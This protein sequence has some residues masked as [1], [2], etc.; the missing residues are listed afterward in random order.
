MKI[1]LLGE[2]SRLHN[3]LKEGL[4]SLGHKVTLLSDGDGFKNFPNDLSIR[5]SLTNTFPLRYFK[6]GIYKIF[7][8]DLSELERGLRCFFLLKK[9]KNFDVVQLINEKP[10]KTTPTVERYLLKRIFYNNTNVF[11][12]S[13]GVDTIS[14][15][16]MM[17]KK[18]RYSLLDPYFTNPKLKNEFNYVLEYNLNSQN[19]THD[20]VFN[21]IKGVIA[22]DFDY[23]LPL[24]NHKQFLGLIPNPVNLKE[25]SFQQPPFDQKIVIFLGIN[26]GTYHAKGIPYFEKA[27]ASI[28]NTYRD[29]VKV[30][31][32]ENIPYNE[33]ITL[34][35][36]AHIVLDQIYSYDQGYNALEAMAQ[37]KV[38]FTGAE[39]EFLDHY[40]LRED[41]V[42]IN[43]LPNVDY[44]IAK[45]SN[46]I[47][48]PEKI[49]AIG[50][51]ARAFIEDKHD[52]IKVAQKYSDTYN[53]FQ[54]K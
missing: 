42:G 21:N 2:Y 41:D 4:I 22:S 15:N 37:G 30:I 38:V 29:R 28:Q 39:K 26:R 9:L 44:L 43:A 8:F 20:L 34:Y 35:N 14:V 36:E 1:L 7:K 11:L 19:K 45:L 6:L 53:K 49:K 40:N 13:C 18:L 12:L 32:V 33:Y 48:N 31:T 51:S 5:A 17:D 25:F 16:Y 50:K 52:S 24:K 27:L 54:N 23:V 46:L 10:I 47:E 3:S